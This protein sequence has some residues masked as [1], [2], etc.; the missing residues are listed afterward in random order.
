MAT[1]LTLHASLSSI[2]GQRGMTALFR[3]SL[4]RTRDRHPWLAPVCETATGQD[5]LDSLRSAL[6]QQAESE[7]EAAQCAL[8]D[9]FLDTLATLIGASLTDR[10]MRAALDNTSSGSAVQGTSS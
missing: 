5:A 7:A 10:L 3:R 6:L 4:Y 1:W 9:N 8:L 2:I